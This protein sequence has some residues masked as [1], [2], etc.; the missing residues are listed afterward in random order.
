MSFDELAG[1]MHVDTETQKDLEWYE[2]L[3]RIERNQMARSIEVASFDKLAAEI[4]LWARCKGF[5]NRERVAVPT[6][7]TGDIEGSV[8]NPSL[9][10]EKLML[11]VS[12]CSEVLEALRNASPKDEAE[13]IADIVIRCLDYAAWR[14]ISL[15][16]EIREKMERNYARPYLHGKN[17]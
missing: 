7:L 6:T 14:G 1:G 13:E 15:D 10:A 12:E 4:H 8:E 3:E 9:A 16:T 5:Y 17:F 2:N 11:I